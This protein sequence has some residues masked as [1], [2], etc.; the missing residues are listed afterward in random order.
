MSN[1]EKKCFRCGHEVIISYAVHHHHVFI[2]KPE[3][4][5]KYIKR[6]ASEAKEKRTTSMIWML[7]CDLC[8]QIQWP[9][10]KEKWQHEKKEA[11]D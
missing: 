5:K 4:Y 3:E 9:A 6:T 2:F 11:S 7:Y 1:I 10:F 8:G